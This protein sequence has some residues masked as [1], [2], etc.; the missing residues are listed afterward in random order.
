MG[1][2]GYG[3][4]VAPR[5]HCWARTAAALSTRSGLGDGAI[6]KLPP[7]PH[8]AMVSAAVL[9]TVVAQVPAENYVEGERQVAIGFAVLPAVLV[10]VVSTVQVAVVAL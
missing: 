3:R 4:G 7:S 8:H 2:R 1:V 6:E 9:R 5:D 10:R